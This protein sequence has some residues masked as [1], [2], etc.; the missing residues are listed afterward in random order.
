MGIRYAV[1]GKYG[2]MRRLLG[3]YNTKKEAETAS[4]IHGIELAND[5]GI[6]PAKLKTQIVAFRTKATKK[7]PTKAAPSTKRKKTTQNRRP[8]KRARYNR[9]RL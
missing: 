7:A 3:V 9:P 8:R 2:R 4:G 6:D 5:A 1:Y